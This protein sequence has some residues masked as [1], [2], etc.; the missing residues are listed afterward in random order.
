[1]K[2]DLP[3][4]IGSNSNITSVVYSQVSST[5]DSGMDG[6]IRYVANDSWAGSTVTWNTMPTAS[7]DE[8]AVDVVAGW[9]PRDVS[10]NVSG[11]FMENG[12][13]TVTLQYRAASENPYYY[14]Q[15]SFGSTDTPKLTIDYVVPEPATIGLLAIGAVSM[16]RK[17]K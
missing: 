6:K 11:I 17:R 12:G 16:L 2:F 14:N 8:Y 1:M 10:G 9:V 4:E 3:A 5:P 7:G 13:Q 15:V